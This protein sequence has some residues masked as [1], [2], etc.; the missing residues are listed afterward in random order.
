MA[1]F[2]K[3]PGKFQVAFQMQLLLNLNLFMYRCELCKQIYSL[4]HIDVCIRYNV[5]ILVFYTHVLSMK[6]PRDSE[7]HD[8]ANDVQL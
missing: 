7:A 2:T 3:L 6:T 4:L 8:V 5:Y 1:F